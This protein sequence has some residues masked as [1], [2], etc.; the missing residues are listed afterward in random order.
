MSKRHNLVFFYMGDFQKPYV[1]YFIDSIKR[2]MPN[3]NIVQFTDQTTERVDGVT[4]VVRFDLP[5]PY[6]Y[7]SHPKILLWCL[8]RSPFTEMINVDA[9]IIFNGDVTP[10]AEGDFDVAICTRAV[11]KVVSEAFI[12]AHKYNGGFMVTKNLDFW[13]RWLEETEKQDYIKDNV[14]RIKEADFKFSSG[15]QVLAKVIDS[16]E[17]N[18]KFLNG[19][20]FNRSPNFKGENNSFTK[21]WH[22]KGPRKEWMAYHNQEN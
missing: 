8:C 22:F 9:D 1:G 10:A 2:H 5:E 6:T 12:R 11:D 3:V 16:G 17:F 14:L 21:V 19:E 13:K 20:V 18:I 4:D 15:Q 7:A